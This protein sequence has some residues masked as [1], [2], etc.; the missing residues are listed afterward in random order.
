MAASEI[1]EK[2]S[3]SSAEVSTEICNFYYKNRAL[4]FWED[5]EDVTKQKFNMTSYN[6]Y[7]T[8]LE[9]KKKKI[10]VR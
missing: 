4:T 7:S 2:N 9:L 3:V 8:M 6:R 10:F 1:C 5:S